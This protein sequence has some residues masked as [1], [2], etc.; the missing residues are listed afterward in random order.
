MCRKDNSFKKFCVRK[1]KKA[2]NG[3]RGLT[4]MWRWQEIEDWCCWKCLKVGEQNLFRRRK[5]KTY[6][7]ELA[8]GI[9]KTIQRKAKVRVELLPSK[10]SWQNCCIELQ[11]RGLFFPKCHPSWEAKAVDMARSHKQNKTKPD[12]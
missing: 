11:Q 10:P 5:G 7:I 9:V 4:R 2:K 12:Y 3:R 6:L 1:V 8:I